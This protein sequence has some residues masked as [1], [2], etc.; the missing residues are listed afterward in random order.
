MVPE[1]LFNENYT[2]SQFDEVVFEC[3][4]TGI[5]APGINWYRNG[6]LLNEASDS[7]ISLG[8]IIVTPP[9][10]STDVYEI[11]RT[12][13][14]NSTRDDDTDTYT[15]VADN[16][17]RRM[18]NA[19]QDIELLITGIVFMAKFTTNRYCLNTAFFQ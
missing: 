11:Y 10:N 15:C 13:T 14:F 19:T 1:I 9:V 16:G 18:P 3:N 2:V 6:N 12:L 7:R 4:A 17:I 8:D 5:P